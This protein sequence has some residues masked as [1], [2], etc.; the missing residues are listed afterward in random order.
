ML[1]WSI[2]FF[3]LALI[4]AV[5]GFG[6]VAS[7]ASGIAQILFVLFV[8]LFIASFFFKAADRADTYVDRNL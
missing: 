4:A 2:A 5:F 3:V 7:A 6:G 1:S 8:I